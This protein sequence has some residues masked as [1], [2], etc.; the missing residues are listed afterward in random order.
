VVFIDDFASGGARRATLIVG[1]TGMSGEDHYDIRHG[2]VCAM[3]SRHVSR[4][5]LH[6]GLSTE[7]RP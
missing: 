6:V 7:L 5:A 4:P 1:L 3:G 2:G